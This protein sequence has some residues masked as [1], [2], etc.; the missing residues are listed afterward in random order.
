MQASFLKL[1]PSDAA[2]PSQKSPVDAQGCF[3]AHF[4]ADASGGETFQ[5]R[6]A[7]YPARGGSG[8]CAL[9][10]LRPLEKTRAGM[11]LDRSAC[12]G[13]PR[14]SSR[15]HACWRSW[16]SRCAVASS[17]TVSPAWARGRRARSSGLPE[18]HG[19]S[20]ELAGRD[21]CVVARARRPF[22]AALLLCRRAIALLLCR[23]VR[24]AARRAA[25]DAARRAAGRAAKRSARR[26]GGRRARRY[27]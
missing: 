27:M 17:Y 15:C 13:T 7:S 24:R 11:T 9:L 3:K 6:R 10:S 18:A 20:G 5:E 23:F 1:D 2:E 19:R 22:D 8:G 21:E 26:A 14:R 12:A 16:R 25:E 4:G